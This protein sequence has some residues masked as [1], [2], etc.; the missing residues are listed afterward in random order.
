MPESAF[1]TERKI[2]AIWRGTPASCPQQSKETIFHSLPG[3]RFFL[4]AKYHDLFELCPRIR[5]P[6]FRRASMGPR[7]GKKACGMNG[8]KKR[9]EKRWMEE[10]EKPEAID[11]F[12]S[13]SLPEIVAASFTT[14]VY[15]LCFLQ[16]KVLPAPSRVWP[17]TRGHW[18]KIESRN[19]V[20]FSSSAHCK[21]LFSMS[22]S[23][24]LA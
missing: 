11:S 9:P 14:L 18:K 12:F 10:R 1:Q 3:E 20:K 4:L 16:S 2:C 19:L 24:P 21:V 8:Q 5:V 23:Q 13:P 6:F 15:V 22:I 17:S 7:E